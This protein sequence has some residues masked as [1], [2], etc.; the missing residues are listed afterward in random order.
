MRAASYVGSTTN[1]RTKDGLYFLVT[2][3]AMLAC[4]TSIVYYSWYRRVTVSM[5]LS[6]A[7]VVLWAMLL[8]ILGDRNSFFLIAL[9]ALA[10]VSTYTVRIRPWSFAL[11]VVG[12]LIVYQ[13]IEATRQLD[14]RGFASIG[15]ALQIGTSSRFNLDESSLT[16]TTITS[17]AAFR[18]VPDDYDYFYGKFKLIGFAGIIPYSRGLLVDPND[19]FVTSADLI[20]V[21]ILG[22]NPTWSLG[23]NIIADIYVDFGIPGV[24]ALMYAMG[25]VGAYIQHRAESHG[26][27]MVWAVTYVVCLATYAEAPR[28]SFDFP[29]RPLTWTLLLLA[30]LPVLIRSAT[31]QISRASDAALRRSVRKIVRP[32]ANQ[33]SSVL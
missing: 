24:I 10:S 2:H 3:L 25:R 13:G 33:P 7:C 31:P 20:T 14:K 17:R 6:A 26:S 32:L 4:A 9:V 28:Y 29:V 11:L 8:L 30:G 19:P 22:D 1:D 12:A 5:T 23:T 21:G 18:I 15:Q 16:N 27:S